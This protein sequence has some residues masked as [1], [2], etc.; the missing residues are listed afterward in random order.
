LLLNG[1]LFVVFGI[2]FIA[3]PEFSARLL[4]GAAPVTQ[5][6]IIDMRATY[7]AT[8]GVGVF[9]GIYAL[10]TAGILP[11]VVALVLFP[12]S[13]ALG[14]V[15]GIAASSRANVMMYVSVLLELLF[16]AAIGRSIA[17]TRDREAGHIGG[18]AA[19]CNPRATSS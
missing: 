15:L 18:I 7:G 12:G 17:G 3:L 2:G 5:S 6:A 13:I 16:F 1:T 4:I 9:F 8:R 19:P 11:G 14:R 10:R